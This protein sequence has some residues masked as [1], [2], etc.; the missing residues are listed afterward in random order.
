MERCLS[1]YEVVSCRKQHSMIRV[2][3]FRGLIVGIFLLALCPQVMWAQESEVYAPGRLHPDSTYGFF[4]RLQRSLPLMGVEV[5]IPPGWELDTV[6]VFD[7][8]RFQA[9]AWQAEASE[10]F[11]CWFTEASTRV[12]VYLRLRTG[13][14][15]GPQRLWI[16]PVFESGRYGERI[17]TWVQ[18]ATPPMSKQQEQALYTDGRHPW[19]ERLDS[20]LWLSG[21]Y[22][23]GGWVRSL[24]F[25]AVVLSSWS[26]REGDPYPFEWLLDERGIPVF[27]RGGQGIH[28]SLMGRRPIADGTWHHV[29]VRIEPTGWM[30]LWVDGEVEDSLQSVIGLLPYTVQTITWGGREVGNWGTFRGYVD[31]WMM[32]MPEGR[33]QE[34]VCPE[35]MRCFSFEDHSSEDLPPGFR[36]VSV[37]RMERRNVRIQSIYV[38]EGWITLSW[39]GPLQLKEGAY[40]L[41]ERS[42]D[43]REFIPVGRV[44]VATGLVTGGSRGQ[45]LFT[46]QPNMAEE[47]V[48]YYRIRLM[49][50]EEMVEST[51]M[52]KVGLSSE[53]QEGSHLV[54]N[55]PNPAFRRTVIRY[56]LA[57]DGF[58]RLSL[59]ELSGHLVEVLEE[60][61]RLA[62]M[63]E[64]ILHVDKLPSGTYIIR[65][66]TEE[67]VD[68]HTLVVMH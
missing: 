68:T 22:E 64:F 44:T 23:V 13:S 25:P 66:E 62:G 53:E 26:G 36:R 38:E 41:V 65:L 49:E 35:N 4:F 43:G 61:F 42:V 39:E 2:Q 17:E 27:Y 1:A 37:V 15:E 21:A 11:R 6:R 60:G 51:G 14:E 5:G 3:H 19:S 45:Y 58:V 9:V 54:G 12:L 10:P 50:K 16:V 28:E 31:D 33:T 8:E 7:E 48:V 59:W 18:V 67:G 32:G 55:F 57:R 40:F 24:E 29:R 46:D 20:P 52:I 63:R 34:G 56:E 47:G 30:R